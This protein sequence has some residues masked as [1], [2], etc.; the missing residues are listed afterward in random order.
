MRIVGRRRRGVRLREGV[1][2][3]AKAVEC[4][5]RGS[6]DLGGCCEELA[7]RPVSAGSDTEDAKPG[8]VVRKE[9]DAQWML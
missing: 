6:A 1:E 2:S 3:V 5:F 9:D 4:N 7:R 8:R